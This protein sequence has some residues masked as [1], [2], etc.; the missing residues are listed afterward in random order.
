MA[1]QKSEIKLP[2]LDWKKAT[3]EVCGESFEYL[4]KRSPRICKNGD[5][6]YKHKH[7]IEPSSWACYQP[8]LF[9]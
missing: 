8:T 1:I 3:C 7:R 9:D 4:G 2:D 5:C 6:R